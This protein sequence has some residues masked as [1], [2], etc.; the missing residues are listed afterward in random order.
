MKRLSEH[1][2][3]NHLAGVEHTLLIVQWHDDKGAPQVRSI[4][5]VT[6]T[7]VEQIEHEIGDTVYKW[8]LLELL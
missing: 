5:D 2:S 8:H 4:R 3:E 1:L 6:P 7:Q